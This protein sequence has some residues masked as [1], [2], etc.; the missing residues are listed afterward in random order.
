M[1]LS[2]INRCP[3]TL[4]E[5]FQGYSPTC[6]EHMFSE[7]KVSHILPY[8]SLQED[9]EVVEQLM[10]SKQRISISGVQ[11]KLSLVLDG[12]GLRL[13]EEK[14]QGTYI[15]KPISRDIKKVTE[16]PANEHLT[17]QIAKQVYHINVAENALIL[18]RNGTPAY[19]TKR[20]DIKP[21]GGK[22]SIEDFAS[23]A[24]K[25]KQHNGSSFK[26]QYNYEKAGKLIQENMTTWMPEIEKYFSLVVFNYL[27]SN[28]DTHLKNFSLLESSTGGYTLSPA[29]D[30]L[31]TRM[32]VG[33]TTFALNQ[34]LFS[35]DFKSS[36]YRKNNHPAK[37]DFVEFGK[38]I[39]M[40][41]N[42]IDSLIAPFLEKQDM[43]NL[44]I[45]R[46]FLSDNCKK[47]YEIMY[48]T[49]RN[50]LNAK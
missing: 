50:Y 15:L 33:D 43:V 14:E 45:K 18:F 17:M 47:G 35:D 28:G 16:V 36:A 46:S 37:T 3:G 42:R 48:N 7:K 24:G 39:G 9:E 11:E 1:N 5:G 29:Y 49:R 44:L 40:K 32:H 30:L 12:N 41:T 27:F 22:W 31:N 2:G 25:T 23:I 13:T 19:L 4:A 20:F 38:R 8:E 6:I 21:E 10:K 26:Y 34:G